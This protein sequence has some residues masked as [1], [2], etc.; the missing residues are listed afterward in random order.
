MSDQQRTAEHWAKPWELDSGLYWTD[1]AAVRQRLNCKVSDNEAED[2]LSYTLRR[3]FINK[4]PWPD[5]IAW[6]AATERLSGNWQ[7]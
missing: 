1:L 4:L 6:A 7:D 3:H 2:W 5:V